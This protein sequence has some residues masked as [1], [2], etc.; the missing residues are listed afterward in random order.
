MSGEQRH[1]DPESNA[2]TNSTVLSLTD[3]YVAKVNAALGAGDDRL[4]VELADAYLDEAI[5][6]VA[7]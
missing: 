5:T 3:A 1:V 7:C 6:G 4:V 2:T